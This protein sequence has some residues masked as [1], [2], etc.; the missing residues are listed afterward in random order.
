MFAY[1]FIFIH[2]VGITI[3]RP[4][5]AQILSVQSDEFWY[6]LTPMKP[7]PQTKRRICYHPR[8]LLHAPSCRFY[9]TSK[10][11]HFLTS[12]IHLFLLLLLLSCLLL[13]S[14]FTDSSS[15]CVCVRACVCVHVYA[16]VSS[17]IQHFGYSY[18]CAYQ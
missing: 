11:N 16:H 8:K 12:F 18:R 15:T 6:L 13:Q 5:K 9:P 4:Q 7:P 2:L 10:Y 17:F 3:Y 14:T 1:S